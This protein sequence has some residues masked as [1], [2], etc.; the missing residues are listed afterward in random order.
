MYRYFSAWANCEEGIVD[1]GI[2]W[3][4]EFLEIAFSQWHTAFRRLFLALNEFL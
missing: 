2:V 3:V 4:V 1:V